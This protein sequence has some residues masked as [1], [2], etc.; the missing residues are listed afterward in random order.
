MFQYN[1]IFEEDALEKATVD[2]VVLDFDEQSKEELLKVDDDIVKN[3]KPHQAKGI[4]FMWDTCF[5]SMERA[6][7]EKGSGC[8]LAHC[9]G[10][11]K[12]LQVNCHL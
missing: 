8:I 12:T 3:L 4:Q 9:M 2:K 10:L 7:K 5:E 1:Q 6:K 11:G